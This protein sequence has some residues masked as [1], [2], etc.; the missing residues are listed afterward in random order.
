[1][2]LLPSHLGSTVIYV[3]LGGARVPGIIT[4]IHDATTANLALVRDGENHAHIE[5]HQYDVA[6]APVRPDGVA[7]VGTWHPRTQL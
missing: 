2:Q 6:Y 4:R 3:G 7:E 1:M 5:P